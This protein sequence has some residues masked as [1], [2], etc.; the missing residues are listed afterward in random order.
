[1]TDDFAPTPAHGAGE[2][3]FSAPE[4]FYLT[5]KLR[6]KNG[7]PSDPVLPR[8]ATRGCATT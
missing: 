5:T 2:E 8:R 6:S 3:V 1:M 7:L 4:L